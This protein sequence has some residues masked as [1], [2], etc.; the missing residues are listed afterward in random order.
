MGFEKHGKKCKLGEWRQISMMGRE[1]GR[2]RGRGGE[3]E[4]EEETGGGGGDGGI[5][6]TVARDGCVQLFPESDALRSM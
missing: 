5:H 1:R 6:S 2:R 4:E 3:E